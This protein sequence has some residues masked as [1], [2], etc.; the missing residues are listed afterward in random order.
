MPYNYESYV[1][2]GTSILKE[3]RREHRLEK[4]PVNLLWELFYD[5]YPLSRLWTAVMGTIQNEPKID[6]IQIAQSSVTTTYSNYKKNHRKDYVIAFKRDDIIGNLRPSHFS[7]FVESACLGNNKSIEEL[8]FGYVVRGQIA[9]FFIDWFTQ[10]L[11]GINK[12]KA[13]LNLVKNI[14]LQVDNWDSFTEVFSCFAETILLE[15]AGTE[16]ESGKKFT[17][18]LY[19]PLPPFYNGFDTFIL[20]LKHSF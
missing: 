9:N 18:S 13:Y 11:T 6:T 1:N 12:E 3:L 8:E 4:Y 10:I 7:K 5:L 20:K 19:K 16:S 17:P 15:T 2:L 14:A